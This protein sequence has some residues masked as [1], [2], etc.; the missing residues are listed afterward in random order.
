MAERRSVSGGDVRL[1][2]ICMSEH[3]NPWRFELEVEEK[4]DEQEEALP[5]EQDDRRGLSTCALDANSVDKR[6]GGRRRQ[7]R[8]GGVVET[9]EFCGDRE[10]GVACIVPH[11]VM[12]NSVH[13]ASC[14]CWEEWL[15]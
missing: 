8:P 4:A 10:K 12:L 6:G 5:G 7:G 13:F 11:S 1:R 2:D 9:G 3:A 14:V 15:A